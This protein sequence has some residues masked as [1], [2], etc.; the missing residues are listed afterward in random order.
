MAHLLFLLRSNPEIS[1]RWGYH[2]RPIHY[3]EPLPD[4]RAIT[5]NQTKRRRDYQAINFN[6]QEQLRL[7]SDLGAAYRVELEEL[8]QQKGPDRFDF[9]NGYFSGFDAAV[10][11]A[12]I[13]HLKPGRVIEIG[14]GYS[15]RIADIALARNRQQGKPGKLTCIE[16][17]P[18]PRLTEANLDIELIAK[19]VEEIRLEFFSC[20]EANDILFIDSSH[21]VKFRN[22]VCY[23]FLEILPRL[24]PGVWVHVHDIF[25]PHDYPAEWLIEQ[26]LA[27]N[28]QYLLE[29]F[30]S[31]NTAFSVSIANHWLSLEHPSEAAHLWEA[32]TTEANRVGSASFWMTR[33]D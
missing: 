23:E 28:E 9:K 11:Y 3:H 24:K 21:T 4:F 7:I 31:Y 20:L 33:Q 12:L 29:A 26:R 15:T 5:E 30:L 18:Q 22:D 8:A 16:P 14:S 2:V 25:F 19:P 13:R 32:V 6:W 1:D 27:L 17:Y 10:Y